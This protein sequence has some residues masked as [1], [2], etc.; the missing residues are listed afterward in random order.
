MLDE[1]ISRGPSA[2]GGGA[3]SVFTTS[4]STSLTLLT[5]EA[6]RAKENAPST[7]LRYA[8]A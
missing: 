8:F 5:P 3:D 6:L 4:P 7:S 2:T 1:V